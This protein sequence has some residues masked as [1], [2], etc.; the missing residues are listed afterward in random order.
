MEIKGGWAVL[1]LAKIKLNLANY[2]LSKKMK[3]EWTGVVLTKKRPIL[4][5]DIPSK[6]IRAVSLVKN[7]FCRIR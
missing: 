2:L 3:G 5:S 1:I 7:K 6:K 4:P